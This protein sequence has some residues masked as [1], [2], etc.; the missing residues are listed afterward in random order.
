MRAG[1]IKTPIPELNLRRFDAGKAQRAAFLAQLRAAAHE[2]GFFYVAGHDVDTH[3]P[4]DPM[5][6]ARNVRRSRVITP[7]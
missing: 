6:S 1:E 2:V 4:R 5:E 7:I 3:L